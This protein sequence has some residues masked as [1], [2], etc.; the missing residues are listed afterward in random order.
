MGSPLPRPHQA[1]EPPTG[2]LTGDVLRNPVTQTLFMMLVVTTATWL[3][4]FVGEQTLFVL[5][6]PILTPPWTLVTSIYAH[7]SFGHLLSNALVILL[8]GGV[9]TLSTTWIRF[10]LFVLVTGVAAGVVQV[11]EIGRAHV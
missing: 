6:P 5:A 8:A 7:A 1:P 11:A 9:V 3:A 2:S 4:T 10:H